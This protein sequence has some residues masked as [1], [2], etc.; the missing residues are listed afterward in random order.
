M[1]TANAKTTSLKI[2]NRA[3]MARLLAVVL[4][5]NLF[6]VGLAGFSLYRSWQQYESRIATQTQNLSHSLSQTIA[7][8]MDKT[9]IVLSSTERNIDRQLKNGSI[10]SKSLNQSILDQQASITELDG[11]GIAN[12]RGE[13][14]YGDRVIPGRLVSIADRSFFIYVKKNP[15]AGLIITKPIISGIT[16]HLA[17]IIVRR[18]NNPDGTFAGI[19]SGAIS[20]DYLSKLISSFDLG[21][22]G[23]ITLRDSE[24]TVIVRFPETSGGK[25]SIGS[26]LVSHELYALTQAGQTSGTYKTPGS[27]DTVERTFSYN[28]IADYPLYVNVGLATSSYLAPW[29]DEAKQMVSLISL[30]I[31]GSLVSS[32]LIYRNRKNEKTAEAELIKYRDQL[33]DTVEKRTTALQT[34]NAQLCEEIV[35]RKQV[36]A[37]LKKAAI[38]LDR[39]PDAVEWISKDGRFMYV[40]DAACNMHKCSR[41]EMLSMSVFEVSQLVTSEVW[42]SNWEELKQEGYLNFEMVK[43]IRDGSEFPVEI[44]ANYLNIDGEEY[45]CAILR[46]ISDRKEAECE[47]QNLMVQLNQSQKIESIGRLSGGIAHDFNNLLTP[48]LGYSELIINGLVPEDINFKRAS[49]IMLAANKAKVLTQQLLS[50]GRKQMLEMKTVDMNKVVLSFYEILRRT[51]RENIEIK[52]NLTENVYGIHA[53]KNQ[54]EQIIMNLTINAQDAISNKGVITIETLPVTLDEEYARQHAGVSPG[55]YLMLAVTDTG[56]GMNQ[57]TLD[58]VF[59]PFFTTKDVGKGTGLGLA[60]V[61]GIVKQHEGHIW[62][63]SEVGKGSVFKSY[64]PITDDVPG[65]EMETAPVFPEVIT[66]GWNILIVD[67]DDMVRNMVHDLLGN[68]DCK[69]MVAG[70][71]MRALEI[72][73]G[74]KIDLLLT[75]IVM[76]DMDGS[77]LHQKLLSAN[78]EM[79]VIYM[80]G[81]T[82][83]IAAT[84]GVINVGANFIQ[85]P[86]TAK[87]LVNKINAILN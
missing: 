73:K 39:M 36:E 7:A 33:E 52:L 58:H 40:N 32:W 41:D 61:H 9:N 57:E 74:Q 22:Q 21:R 44:T 26:N 8:L 50:F 64:F 56:S 87:N 34:K 10:D 59:E 19:V 43:Q 13:V 1:V 69:V 35:L 17:L 81:Y 72:S 63:Y 55:K 12:A 78:H 86:F 80:S 15:N 62:I 70:G 65:V 76:P 67:D 49:N 25:S 79:K 84:H 60:T 27:I 29:R 85:K 11:L 31:I 3:F 14:I 48:I 75:D 37:D 38:V 71:P 23:V 28:K 16:K 45:N 20:L 47:K 2:S 66:G 53:D 51:I 54:L 5:I 30:F 46:D 77:E 42:R 6:I 83:N 4:L 68:Y 24:M 18:I 82:N